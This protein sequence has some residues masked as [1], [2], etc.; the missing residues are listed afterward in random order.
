MTP[1]CPAPVVG[2]AVPIGGSPERVFASEQPAIEIAPASEISDRVV[3]TRT[4]HA[5][6]LPECA[7]RQEG[8]ESTRKVPN[9]EARS[10]MEPNLALTGFIDSTAED[11]IRYLHTPG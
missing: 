1:R 9:R 4:L 11:G 7:Q 8:V 10:A 3:A 6:L 2:R 5:S